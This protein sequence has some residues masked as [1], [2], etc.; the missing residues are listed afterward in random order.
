MPGKKTIDVWTDLTPN[1]LKIP[2][3]EENYKEFII[4][5]FKKNIDDIIK[6]TKE[7]PA[8]MTHPGR[9]SNIL[10][11]T[12]Q[13]YIEGKF[14]SCVVMCGITAERIAQDL[15]RVTILFRKGKM[16]LPPTAEQ[17]KQLEQIPLETVRELLIATKVIEN[18]LKSQFTKIAKLRNKYAHGRG[19]NPHK[20]AIKAISSLHQVIEG[21][22]SVFKRF[23]IKNGKF[24]PKTKTQNKS[25]ASKS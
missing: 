5:E 25:S 22:V 23:D 7:L 13:L 3:E 17:G 10:L 16:G 21:T 20:D 12:R 11:E 14:Y 8:I 15:L 2:G 6:R 9:Y 4:Q 1:V 18:D 19:R 24:V